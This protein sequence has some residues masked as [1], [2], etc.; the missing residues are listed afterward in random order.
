MFYYSYFTFEALLLFIE[1]KVQQYNSFYQQ[2]FY[3]DGLLRRLM[4]NQSFA[5]FVKHY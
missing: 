3:R 2:F 1:Y 4:T 5:L